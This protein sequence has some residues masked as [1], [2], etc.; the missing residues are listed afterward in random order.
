[1][2]NPASFQIETAI[3]LQSTVSREPRKLT[4]EPPKRPMIWFKR[5]KPGV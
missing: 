4:S 2:K 1:M 5:P 3:T